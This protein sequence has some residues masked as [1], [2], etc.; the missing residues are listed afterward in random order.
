MYNS[1]APYL[2]QRMSILLH[3]DPGRMGAIPRVPRNREC[4]RFQPSQLHLRR[5]P[6]PLQLPHMQH[7]RT[8][9]RPNHDHRQKRHGDEPLLVMRRVD[10]LPYKQRQPRLQDIRHF[11]HA[12]NDKR[13]LFVVARADFVGPRHD[14]A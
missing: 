8:N 11:I 7:F 6:Q 1:P 13:A 10:L 4:T 2:M 9:R 5:R 3:S 12:A 14:D